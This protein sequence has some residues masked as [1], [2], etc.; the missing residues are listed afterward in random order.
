MKTKLDIETWNRKEHFEFFGGLLR[1][2]VVCGLIKR[3][4]ELM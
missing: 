3:A 4:K 1:T 2:V